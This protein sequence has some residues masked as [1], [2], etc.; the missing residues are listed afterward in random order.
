M[1]NHAIAAIEKAAH[2]YVDARDT[3]MA[4]GTREQQRHTKLL[5][6][7]KKYG[8][9]HYAHNDGDEVLEVNLAAKDATV[10][11]KVR[12]V[13]VDE[14]GKKTKR[15]AAEEPVIGGDEE[16][17]LQIDE[18][19]DDDDDLNDDDDDDEGEDEDDDEGEGDEVQG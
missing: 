4:A 1:E 12:I 5:A 13:P 17:E 2:E 6:E 19:G 8:K 7:M 16:P 15:A 11:A 18:P 3:R 9:Q 10:K 14:Y